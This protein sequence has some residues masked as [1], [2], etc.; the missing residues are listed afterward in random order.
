MAA[1]RSASFSGEMVVMTENSM[2]RSIRQTWR[3]LR[4]ERLMSRPARRDRRVHLEAFGQGVPQQPAPTRTPCTVPCIVYILRHIPPK[5]PKTP[6]LL[7]P[8]S[9]PLP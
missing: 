8:I 3:A 1:V 4:H 9:L 7:H 6:H 2:G 5:A